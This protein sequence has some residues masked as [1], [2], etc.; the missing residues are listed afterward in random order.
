MQRLEKFIEELRV[1]EHPASTEEILNFIREYLQLR[2]LQ[3]IYQSKFG[4]CLSFMGGTCLRICYNL[5]RYSEDLDFALDGDRKMYNFSKMMD[6]LAREMNLRGFDTS[7]TLQ[8]DKIVQK[9]FFRVVGLYPHFRLRGP[10]DQKIHIK[11]EVDTRP[12]PLE[13]EERESYFVTRF[14]EIFPILKHTLPTLFAGKV[15]AVLGR[16]YTRGRDYYDLIWYLTQKVEVNLRYLQ[17]GMPDYP[18]SDKHSVIAELT[19][20]IESVD[21]KV[22]LK[23]I[24]RF[25]EDPKEADWI[26]HY[27]ELF[28]QLTQ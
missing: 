28:Y 23:D 2:L 20:K 25:L 26:S 3:S 18:F 16:A 21:P 27:S 7:V 24:G 10:R 4:E 14:G 13:V 22:V 6:L 11:L 8:E 15:M 12:I 5:K 17:A 19:K 1:R 9:A